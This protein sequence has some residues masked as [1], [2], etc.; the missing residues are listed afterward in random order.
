MFCDVR[1]LPVRAWRDG[2]EAVGKALFFHHHQDSASKRTAR[3][4]VNHEITHS[5][6]LPLLICND[7][8]QNPGLA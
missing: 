8:N 3:D 5:G 4:A 7:L 6:R 2:R 1:R